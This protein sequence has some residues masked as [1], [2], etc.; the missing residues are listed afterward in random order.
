MIGIRTRGAKEGGG[1]VE[2]RGIEETF[3][4]FQQQFVVLVF[5]V[6][7]LLSVLFDHPILRLNNLL[8][9]RSLRVNF[10]YN[11][12]TLSILLY[13]LSSPLSPCSTPIFLLKYLSVILLG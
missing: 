9:V 12:I 8:A 6:F 7:D 10:Y 2:R 5:F 11:I 13:P 1:G 3:S 4:L